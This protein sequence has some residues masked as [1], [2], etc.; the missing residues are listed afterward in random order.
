MRSNLADCLHSHI[1]HG[2]MEENDFIQNV[3]LCSYISFIIFYS[4]SILRMGPASE[5]PHHFNQCD[6]SG[7]LLHFDWLKYSFCISNRSISDYHQDVGT[8]NTRISDVFIDSFIDLDRLLFGKIFFKSSS[9]LFPI[10]F[11]DFRFDV[12]FT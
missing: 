7:I 2:S 11:G 3:Y 8:L 4:M 10:R 1:F 9:I 6:S 5:L 12:L